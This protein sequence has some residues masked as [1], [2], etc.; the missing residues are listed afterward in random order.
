M[1]QITLRGQNANL[2]LTQTGR[3]GPQGPAGDPGEGVPTGGTAG[4]VLTKQSNVDYDTEWETTSEGLSRTVSATVSR[5]GIA[6]Y[7]CDGTDDNVQIQQAI[8]YV[9]SLGGGVV[10]LRANQNAYR[11]SATITV[12]ENVFIVGEKWARM[13]FGG[14]T[15]Q[16]SAA[17]NLDNMFTVTGTQ[18]PASNDDLL[19]DTGFIN[20]TLNGNSTTTTLIRYSNQDTS[21][22]KHCRLIGATVSIET[23]WDA[24]GAP[25]PDPTPAT[26]PGGLRIVD[27]NIS[28]VSGQGIVLNYQTQS[29]ITD[30]WFTGSNVNDWIVINNSNKITV[31]GCE[32]NTADSAIRLGDTATFP[33][34][35]I[36]INSNRFAVGVNSNLTDTRTNA[37]SDR[38]SFIG[39]T[40]ANGISDTLQ[41]TGNIVANTDDIVIEGMTS[42]QDIH[43]SEQKVVNIADG[44]DPRDAVNKQQLDTKS[45]D[46]DVVKLAGTQ[47][48]TGQKSFNNITTFNSGM[49]TSLINRTSDQTL[50]AATPVV[51]LCNATSAPIAITLPAAAVGGGQMYTIK[52]TD[53]S[54]NNVTV[55]TTSG[56]LIDGSTTYVLGL[57]Y[58]S[59]TVVSDGSAWHVISATA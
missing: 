51:N 36:T 21:T 1:T 41:G 22:V 5:S 35:D 47:T 50:A 55:Q 43:M 44:T 6:D 58:Q 53:V 52:K 25:P 15:L 20:L 3:V 8:D 24:T 19:H 9:D 48:V 23:V 31:T 33:A 7:M 45:N 26:I 30:C 46:A 59:V 29:W 14:V 38:V 39:N 16:T 13:A 11:I 10:L 49:R 28:S 17:V 37:S 42:T 12:P 57:Q 54:A 56:Q 2:I 40:I 4:Q 34:N 27:C 32:F 18:N